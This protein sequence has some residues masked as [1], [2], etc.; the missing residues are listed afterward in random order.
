MKIVVIADTHNL[1][2][3]LPDGDMLIH[4]GDATMMGTKE[5]VERFDMWLGTL[6]YKYILFVPGN[7]DFLFEKHSDS[8]LSNATVL[9]NK[10]IVIDGIKFW[11]SPYTLIFGGWVFMKT[12]D[13][14]NDIWKLIPDDVDVVITH[15]PPRGILDLSVK[16]NK[17][18]GSQSLLGR[19]RIVKP[20]V[21]VFGHIHEAHGEQ[22]NRG[23]HYVNASLLNEY[24]QYVNKPTVI[25]I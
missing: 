12:D 3:A 23:M 20:K 19:I 25:E 10:E 15:G 22:Y 7:H 6:N 13:K 9:I 1:I 5:E 16:Y 8:L 18:S 14:L 21:H 11:G 4:A 17:N 24:Y 2:P